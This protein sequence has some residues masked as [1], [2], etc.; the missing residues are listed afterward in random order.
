MGSVMTR[1]LAPSPAVEGTKSQ[2]Y[3]S[4]DVPPRSS[5]PRATLAN[6]QRIRCKRFGCNRFFDPLGP[7][8]ECIHHVEPPALCGLATYWSCCPDQKSYAFEDFVK[9][10][11]C[12]RGFCSATLTHPVCLTLSAGPV[13]SDGCVDVTCTNL[14]GNEITSIRA[15]QSTPVRHLRGRIAEEVCDV[16]HMLLRD[17]R[18]ISDDAV[19]LADVFRTNAESELE[20]LG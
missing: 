7:P 15:H 16:F 9:I 19:L 2:R 13:G 4:A 6:A 3:G 8:Q 17:G 14:A 12:T 10:P 20:Q 1:C 5:A 18:T 11:G